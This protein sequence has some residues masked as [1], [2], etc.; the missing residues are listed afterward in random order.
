MMQPMQHIQS[1]QQVNPYYN[2][3]S[4]NMYPYSQPVQ[5]QRQIRY[6][7][8]NQSQPMNLG[9]NQ[10]HFQH[11]IQQNPGQ[12]QGQMPSQMQNQWHLQQVSVPLSPNKMAM[13][14]N[15]INDFGGRPQMYTYNSNINSNPNMQTNYS[16]ISQ[17]Y[18]QIN[19]YHNNVNPQIHNPQNYQP[20]NNQFIKQQMPMQSMNHMQPMPPMQNMPMQQSMQPPQIQN[21][22]SMQQN[23]Q[24]NMQQ[25]IH[26]NMQPIQGLQQPIH[27]MQ[28]MNSYVSNQQQQQ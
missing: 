15:S 23:M 27:P 24:M 2:Y 12:Q 10:N 22:Q 19:K 21:M 5:D 1:V 6:V 20:P 11:P 14:N 13:S 26:Q 18:S 8:V 17:N 16:H 4:N 25:P 7:P 9:Y 28:Q 3:P